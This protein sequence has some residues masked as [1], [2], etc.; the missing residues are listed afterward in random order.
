MQLDSDILR[1]NRIYY[2]FLL[3]CLVLKV[4]SYNVTGK[5]ILTVKLQEIKG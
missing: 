3:C 4:V 1:I 2:S 5:R